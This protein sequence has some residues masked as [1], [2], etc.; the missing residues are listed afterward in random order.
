MVPDRSSRAVAERPDGSALQDL[1]SHVVPYELA[2]GPIPRRLLLFGV[3]GSV[4]L[5]ATGL[6]ALILPAPG[7]IRS[8]QFFWF[9]APA[10]ATVVGWMQ[11]I[12]LPA[13]AVGGAMLVVDSYLANGNR[14]EHWRPV[15]GAQSVVG[16]LSGVLSAVFLA[17]VL[18]IIVIYIVLGILIIVGCCITLY[19]LAHMS[20]G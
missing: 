5:L 20:S 13:V 11:A 15:V 9:E 17:F 6:L 14:S 1:L 10:A 12:A 7:V 18:F 3:L 16:N 2:G 19:G 4:L 8:S